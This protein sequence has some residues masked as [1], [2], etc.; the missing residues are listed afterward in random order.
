MPK[1]GPDIKMFLSKA[2]AVAVAERWE[3]YRTQ[4]KP[5]YNPI[6]WGMKA[7]DG[8]F[9]DSPYIFA[10][11]NQQLR[12]FYTAAN[13][14]TFTHK[15]GAEFTPRAFADWFQKRIMLNRISVHRNRSCIV[16]LADLVLD[17]TAG[18]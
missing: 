2:G 14:L 4:L 6:V 1:G 15:V 12:D 11:Y 17:T 18:T 13:R 16:V 8:S 7:T 9:A 3:G 10:A 5:A